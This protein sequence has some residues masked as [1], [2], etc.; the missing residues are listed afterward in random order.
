MERWKEVCG[1]L[2]ECLPRSAINGQRLD[3]RSDIVAVGCAYLRWLWVCSFFCAGYIL[4]WIAY[5]GG[6]TAVAS[7]DPL[8]T[9]DS[10]AWSFRCSPVCDAPFAAGL[11]QT[12][13][14]RMIAGC[15][16]YA[17]SG[18]SLF[19][20]SFMFGGSGVG[21]VFLDTTTLAARRSMKFTCRP[22]MWTFW[23]AVFAGVYWGVAASIFNDIEASP[24]SVCYPQIYKVDPIHNTS[25]GLQSLDG[26]ALAGGCFVDVAQN[27][28][29]DIAARMRRYP[30]CARIVTY[31]DGRVHI[32]LEASADITQSIREYRNL[33]L[34]FAPWLLASAFALFL[35][36]SCGDWRAICYVHRSPLTQAQRPL[37]G[38]AVDP[39]PPAPIACAGC[40]LRLKLQDALLR[41]KSECGGIPL[42]VQ[43][44]I[45]QFLL[46]STEC[47]CPSA[48]CLAAPKSAPT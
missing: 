35:M 26:A 42:E 31:T 5:R 33:I 24:T 28:V 48:A 47:A 14:D 25:I 6:K 40:C 3:R 19:L 27:Q 29:L 4:L 32:P 34:G 2:C 45:V 44:I 11:A 30:D 10:G 21:F 12:G 13:Q 7:N 23:L 9:A 20:I 41:S 16:L 43:V 1:R 38:I 15:D 46:S 22:P 17:L 8:G 18:S 36:K 39:A 37:D